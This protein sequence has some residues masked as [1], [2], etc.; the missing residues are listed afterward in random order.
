METFEFIPSVMEISKNALV[1]GHIHT[2]CI[3][4][5]VDYYTSLSSKK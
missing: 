4:C 5:M 3:K 1:Y 2:V